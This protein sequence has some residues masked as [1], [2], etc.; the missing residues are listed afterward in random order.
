MLV[1]SDN[2][3]DHLAWG[4]TTH[5]ECDLPTSITNKEGTP[6]TNLVGTFSQM[7]FFL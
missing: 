2:T 3:Q 1:Q 4:G 6:Q 7:N 5:S